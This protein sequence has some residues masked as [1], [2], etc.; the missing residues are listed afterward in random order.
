M[1]R[2]VEQVI[3]YADAKRRKREERNNMSHQSCETGP[4]LPSSWFVL[5]QCQTALLAVINFVVDPH[6]MILAAS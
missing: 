5:S 4:P 6:V 3:R 1:C 2:A